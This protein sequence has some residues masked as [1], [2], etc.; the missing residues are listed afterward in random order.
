MKRLLNIVWITCAIC[1]SLSGQSIDKINFGLGNAKIVR[2][3]PLNDITAIVIGKRVKLFRSGLQVAT[4]SAHNS[5][6][7][8]LTFDPDG[9]YLMAGFANG[10]VT[11]W[12]MKSKEVQADFKPYHYPVIDCEFIDVSGKLAILTK[13]NVSIWTNDGKAVTE[14]YNH[15]GHNT[16]LSTTPDGGMIA[17]ADTDQRITF[18]DQQLETIK[19]LKTKQA[20]ILSLVFAP[21]GKSIASGDSKGVIDLWNTETGEL[22]DNL[23]ETHGRINS[24]EF[25]NDSKYLAAGSEYFFILSVDR[26]NHDVII[27]KLNGAVLSSSFSPDGK[28]VCIIE[29]LTPHA[30]I[31]DVSDLNIPPIFKLRD[32]GDVI[33]PQ[34]Y[35]S[36]PP[37]IVNDRINY[38]AG[39]I[40]LQGSIFDDY[41]VRSLSINGIETP[42]KENGKFLIHVPLTMGENEIEIQARDINGNIALKKFIINRK[43]DTENYDYTVAK[44][45]LFV[46]GI[47]DYQ[48]WPTLNNAVKDGNDLASIMMENYDFK[49]SDI[50][51]LKN[52]QATKNNIYKGLRGMIEKVSPQDNLM[53]YFSGHGHFDELLNEGYWI[54]TEAQ[55]DAPGDYLSNTSILKIIESINTQ[56]TFLVADACFSGSLF[57][58]AQRGGYYDKVDR[59]K[60]RWGLASGRLEA[61]SDGAIG[62]NSPFSLV[63][64]NFLRENKEQ[65]FSVSEL[66]QHVKIRVSEVSNQTPIGNPLRM[67]GDE[68]GEFVFRRVE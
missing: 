54:P 31:F 49:F 9:T 11:I 33:A 62:S 19:E 51:F 13:E 24:L 26:E 18:Y 66:I 23:L 46:V 68:G 12:E 52:E 39:L 2:Y 38:S 59:F 4:L 37:K 60:S 53:I 30:E 14:I 5:K 32:E 67:K 44:N 36:N 21:N 50:T 10:Y 43:S 45:F 58:D 47:D 28:E 56:H 63:L 41:G 48:E 6:I 7:N 17:T 55:H 57:A 3:S 40:D 35:V 61:V 64:L 1:S 20:Y 27:K 22:T 34:I 29:D 25:S 65:E 42:I 8:S 16:A 15:Y